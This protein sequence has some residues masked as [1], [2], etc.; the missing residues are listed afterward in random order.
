MKTFLT[1]LL[2]FYAFTLSAQ[3]ANDVSLDSTW[4][5]GVNCAGKTYARIPE[6]HQDEA[7]VIGAKVTNVG[8]SA[9]L[10][11]NLSIQ[12]LSID[13]SIVVPVL[14]SDSSFVFE[15]IFEQHLTSTTYTCTYQTSSEMDSLTGV[16]GLNNTASYTFKIEDDIWSD[17]TMDG[18]GVYSNPVTTSYSTD[19]ISENVGY[20]YFATLYHFT[21]YQ[22]YAGASMLL[23]SNTQTSG[24]VIFYLIDSLDFINGPP[25]QIL[26]GSQGQTIGSQNIL[27]GS[28]DGIIWSGSST[29][30]KY[31]VAELNDFQQANIAVVDDLTVKQ[32][33][34]ASL[35]FNPA[36]SSFDYSPNSLAL[37]LILNPEGL[38][39][40]TIPGVE[41]FPNP[42]D[43]P[44]RI[45]NENYSALDIRIVD[46]SG[47]Q[48]VQ[49][50]S[51]S[52]VEFDLLE[53]GKGVYLVLIESDQGTMSRRIVLE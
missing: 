36:D 52:D 45:K 21:D 37:R 32:P 10:N 20:V 33:A 30:S 12:F 9:Q 41:V 47:K 29:G 44:V 49:F 13:T 38:D 17:Y 48:I 4:F 34:H 50:A 5:V 11:V 53:F 6:S 39:E 40:Y 43:G 46:L 28:I 14:D 3:V 18:I 2:S 15:L 26:N 35:I 27:N 16:N 25:F 22:M 42:T 1:L 31:L 8:D 19:S 7:Y 51:K 24:S 23:G